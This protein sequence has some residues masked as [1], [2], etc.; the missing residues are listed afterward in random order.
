MCFIFFLFFLFFIFVFDVNLD[1]FVQLTLANY[2][3]N[4]QVI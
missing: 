2:L 4:V 3:K 1:I